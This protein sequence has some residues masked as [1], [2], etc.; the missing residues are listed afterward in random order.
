MRM[1][2]G[3][4]AA[5]SGQR[6]GWWAVGGLLA[7]VAAFWLTERAV[8]WL[9]MGTLGYRPVFWRILD[10]RF[11]LFAA[12]FVP[13]ALYFWLNLRWA[14]RVMAAWRRQP[15]RRWTRRSPTS[16]ALRCCAERCRAC[17]R[18]FSRSASPVP[19][20]TRS[21][22]STARRSGSRIRS[23]GVMPGSMS[24]GYRCSRR[25]CAGSSWSRSS[26]CSRRRG[27]AS[28]S[29]CSATGR[30]STTRHGAR[31]HRRCAGTLSWSRSRP[32]P[33][34]S[35]IA[36]GCSTRRAAPSGAPVM[37]RCTW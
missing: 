32:R 24:S 1:I 31:W 30:V 33:D 8:D 19:G 22:S 34:T 25:L 12:A 2:P 20:T 10:L 37:S 27:S 36:F 29:G 13:L 14:L 4:S 15:A 26:C 7:L 23:S 6:L 16:S 11:A 3:P 17:S 21:A 18:S 28:G 35:S 5:T 9:W